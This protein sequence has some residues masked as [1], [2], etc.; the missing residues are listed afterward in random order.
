VIVSLSENVLSVGQGEAFTK[1][2]DA[3]DAAQEGDLF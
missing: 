3:V 2:Q 1:I